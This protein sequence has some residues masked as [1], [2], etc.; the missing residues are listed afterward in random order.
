MTKYIKK[1]IPKNNIELFSC[2][3]LLYFII[4][5]F[6]YITSYSI[7]I[8]GIEFALIFQQQFIEKYNMFYPNPDSFPYF[9]S[10]YPPLYPYIIKVF[11]EMKQF[12]FFNDMHEILVLGRELSFLI[13]FIIIIFLF[14]FFKL[15][16]IEIKYPYLFIVLFSLLLTQ[17]F[18][19][20]RPD[21]FKLLFF[22]IFMY[23]ITK[24][25]LDIQARMSLHLAIFFAMISTM[26]KH[27]VAIYFILYFIVHLLTF[28]NVKVIKI[29]IYYLTIVCFIFALFTFVNGEIFLKNIFYYN[30]QYSSQ[31]SQKLIGIFINIFRLSPLILVCMLNFKSENKWIRFIAFYA[32]TSFIISSIFLLRVGSNLNYTYESVLLLLLNSIL[33]FHNKSYKKIILILPYLSILVFLHHTLNYKLFDFGKDMH[34]EKIEY[35][36]NLET[37]KQLKSI[38]KKDVV[39]FPNGKFIIFNSE[40]NILF[41]YDLHLDRFTDLYLNIPISSNLYKND[42]VKSYDNL[43]EQGY[44]KYIVIENEP[45]SLHQ[46]SVFY[47]NFKYYTKCNQFLIYRYLP[48]I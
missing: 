5:R 19:A 17:H 38:I 40:L 12:D 33:Y 29:A 31:T 10:F 35:Y 16:K 24:Y 32:F 2:I 45:R 14:R 4:V 28:R 3:F 26:F 42:A 7:D 15:L 44:V 18:F 21:S 9:I 34:S 23:Y 13:Y 43:F 39:F 37:S 46:M 47:P 20:F 25:E 41:G 1:I 8:A 11:I 30:I 36:Q 48:S 27:D 22:V 6:A